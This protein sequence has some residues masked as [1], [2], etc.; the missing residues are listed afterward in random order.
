MTAPEPPFPRYCSPAEIRR[1]QFT[2][3]VR[4][5]DEDE[6]D[7]YLNLLADQVEATDRQLARLREENARLRD[8]VE[9]LQAEKARLEAQPRARTAEEVTPQVAALLERTQLIAD[10]LVEE[11]VRRTRDMLTV[12]RAE[13]RAI[14]REAHESA[15]AVLREARDTP[16]TQQVVGQRTWRL[17]GDVALS[18]GF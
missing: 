11:A 5:L 10:G 1:E 7:V 18:S 17:D 15:A 2:R 14:I 6:V 8:Q 12:A 16:G 3:R 4:G 13:R 9:V